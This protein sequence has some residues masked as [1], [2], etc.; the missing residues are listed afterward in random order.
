VVPEATVPVILAVIVV[1]EN[2]LL[3]AVVAVVLGILKTVRRAARV[4][5]VRGGLQVKLMLAGLVLL[6]P[7]LL[8]ATVIQRL[9]MLR[10]IRAVAVAVL[11]LVRPQQVLRVVTAGPV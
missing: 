11:L 10:F 7:V 1:W 2:L 3:W 6:T 5:E 4:V 8:V 9:L